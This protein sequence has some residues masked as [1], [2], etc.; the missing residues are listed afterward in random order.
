[1]TWDTVDLERDRRPVSRSKTGSSVQFAAI[2]CGFI[3]RSGLTT[4]S[5]LPPNADIAESDRHVRFVPKADSCS[6]AKSILIR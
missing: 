1:M 3:A 4:M 2:P 6:A 5:A